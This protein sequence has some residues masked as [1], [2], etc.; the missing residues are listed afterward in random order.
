MN[1]T[2]IDFLTLIG[3]VGLFLYGMKLMSEGLQKIAGDRLRSILAI[4][5]NNRFSGMITGILV[6]ALVQSSSATTVMIVSFVNAGLISLAQSM[7]VIMG[8]NVGT[9]ITTWIIAIFGFKFNISIFIFPLIAL[10]LPLFTSS[11]NKKNSWGEFIIGFALLFLGLDSLNHSVPDLKSNQELFALLTQYSEMGYLSII[12]FVLIGM[13]LT[14]IVQASS[15]SFTIALIM[16]SKGWISFEMG[17]ALILGSNIGTC[18]TPL[19]ASFSGNTMAKRAA[20]GHLL[21]NVLGT[22]WALIF[23]YP[24]CRLV[25]WVTQSLGEGDPTELITF[26]NGLEQTN[27]ALASSL[28]AQTVDTSDPQAASALQ[29]FTAYQGSVSFAMTIF[30]TIFNLINLTI[31]IWM[32]KVYVTIVSKLIPEKSNDQEAF[33]LKY[34]SQ[35]LIASGEISLLQVKKETIRYAEETYRMFILIQQMLNERLGSEKQIALYEQVK[36]LENESD[37]AEVEIASFLN[38]ISTKALSPEGELLSRQ[39]YKMVDELESVADSIFHIACTLRDKSE[40]RSY[41][42]PEMN[43]DIHKMIA[44]VD[45]AMQH[46]IKCIQRN[47]ISEQALNRAYNYEDEINNLRNQLRNAIID[48]MNKELELY[49]QSTFYMDLINECEKVGDYIINV[50]TA[51]SDKQHR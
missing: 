12:I 45:V 41:F 39:L 43:D 14:M 10:T 9:T 31:M 25:V 32:T 18:I 33:S 48:Q 1:Y 46:M 2:W 51:M 16:C 11:N 23:Y 36:E 49:Q 21:F 17:C 5:T 44:L 19:I 29:T 8:A 15:A 35:G 13:V 3:S 47:E 6:T 7:A 50:L 38:H 26:I 4:M 40:A 27:P 20:M 22:F 37:K 28:T 34:I 42:T 30:H 24:F